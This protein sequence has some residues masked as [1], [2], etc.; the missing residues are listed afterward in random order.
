MQQRNLI[1]F[2][3]ISILI[4]V[5]WGWVQNK[6][7]PRPKTSQ[8]EKTVQV[9]WPRILQKFDPAA[10]AANLIFHRG[11]AMGGVLDEV[12]LGQ[13]LLFTPPKPHVLARWEDLTDDERK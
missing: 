6:F 12:R 7:W 5:G 4:L 10:R 3:V 2:A 11:L 8:E 13:D 1:L 9:D